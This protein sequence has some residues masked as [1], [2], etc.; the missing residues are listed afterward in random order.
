MKTPLNPKRKKFLLSVEIE[1]DQ[2]YIDWLGDRIGKAVHWLLNLSYEPF[3]PRKG[4]Y[5]L[6]KAWSEAKI[7]NIKREGESKGVQLPLPGIDE[8]QITP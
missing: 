5:R 8:V 2:I 4:D 1:A 3:V 6:S 7:I